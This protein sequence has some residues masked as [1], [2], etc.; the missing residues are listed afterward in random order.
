M[1][2]TYSPDLRIELIA[3]GEQSGTWGTTTNNNLGTIIEDAISGMVQ[4]VTSG[5]KYA[6]T[7]ANGAVDEARCA[8]LV[9]DTTYSPSPPDPAAKYEVYAPPVTKLYVV[10]NA[11]TIRDLDLYCA[12]TINGTTAA[13]A[14]YTIPIGKTAFVRSDGTQFYDATDY[15][16]GAVTFTNANLITP[17]L[18]GETYSTAASV[19]AGTNLQGQGALTADYNI[20]TSAASNPSGVT[21]PTATTGRRIIIVNKGANPINVFPATGAAIDALSTNASTQIPVDGVLEFNA[22]STTRWY[23][24]SA[25]T[26]TSPLITTPSLVAARVSTSASVTAGTNLQGQGALTSDYNVITSAASNPSGVTLPTA[27]IGRKVLV[28]NKGANSVNVYPA[29][30]AAIDALGA[31]A[32]IALPVNGVLEFNASSTTQ[33]YSSYNATTPATF[34]GVSFTGTA[35]TASV[36]QVAVYGAAGTSITTGATYQFR[37]TSTGQAQIQ[38]FED[39]D[40]GTNAVAIQTPAA[41]AASY[42]LTLPPDDGTA[43]Q[44]LTTDGTGT[45]SW[46]NPGTGNVNF[47]GT[48]PVAGQVTIYTDTTG[49][50]LT[51]GRTYQF[52]ATNAGQAQLQLFE[53][54]DTGTNSV[55]I[56][57]PAAL[58]ADYT[59]TLPADDGNAGQL[60][61]TDGA[62]VLSWVSAGGT[63]NVSFTGTVPAAAGQV[64]VYNDTLGTSITSTRTYQFRASS[65]GQAQLQLFETTTNGTNSVTI[66]PPAALAADYTL[67]LPADDGTANQVLTTNGTGT[68]SWTTPASGTGDVVGPAS[69]TDNA[70]VRFDLATGKLVQNSVG[71]LTDAGALSGVTMAAGVITSG[72]F[73]AARIPSSLNATQL[74][75]G[76]SVGVATDSASW[77]LYIANNTTN[78]GL[79]AFNNSG[80]GTAILVVAGTSTTSN[81]AITFQYTA[82]TAGAGSEVGKITVSNTNTTYGTGSDYRL[83]ENVVPLTDAITRLKLLSPKRFTW[84]ASPETGAVDGFI[85]HELQAVVPSAATG[86]KDEVDEN[87]KP[88]IQTVDTSY[89]VPLLTAALQ[90]AVTRIEALEARLANQ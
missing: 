1:P 55:I 79:V 89:L 82:S 7:A 17:S 70:L 62:G 27:T 88:V 87:G 18:S 65:L 78:P 80:S 76:S 46:T 12:T 31:N 58:A 26:L 68:L 85:A 14:A 42:T 66:Q 84:K 25:L 74:A 21:L 29:T 44:V 51:T 43:N 61:S 24:F 52:R 36:N 5:Q 15:I 28:V 3:N 56:Q 86:V 73:S 30:G 77:P 60:L 38:L 64:T 83:K 39:T 20:I 35:P 11:S 13:G 16:A 4:I 49:N 45:L 19:T 8:I 10:K 40:N 41:L 57:P 22:S 90:E 75:I 81:N 69:A 48:A 9:L 67:T 34:T 33:W 32:S 53:D 47:T 63:G 50:S 2:S 54:T 23:S 72:T 59:L 71:I 6:L 37:A